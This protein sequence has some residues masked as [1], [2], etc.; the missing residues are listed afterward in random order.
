MF[1]WS[2]LQLL[3]RKH[4]DV[5]ETGLCT[6]PDLMLLAENYFGPEKN[7]KQIE[8]HLGINA[9]QAVQDECKIT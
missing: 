2:F 8:K 1:K 5:A 4:A 9:S 7:G 6:V 3:R